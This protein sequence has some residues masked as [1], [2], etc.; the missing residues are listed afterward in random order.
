MKEFWMIFDTRGDP[1]A[2]KHIGDRSDLAKDCDKHQSLAA[3]KRLSTWAKYVERPLCSLLDANG[4]RAS[5]DVFP[6]TPHTIE[7]VSPSYMSMQEGD[8]R[9]QPPSCTANIQ[10]PTSRMRSGHITQSKRRNTTDLWFLG[11]AS[12]RCCD[13]PRHTS[14]Y[15]ETLWWSLT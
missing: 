11:E 14:L 3:T 10:T 1:R 6:Q 5:G 7:S 8:V 12:P 15:I 13:G 9:T 4:R 2:C